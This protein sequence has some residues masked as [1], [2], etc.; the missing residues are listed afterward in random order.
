[1]NGKE[2]GFSLVMAVFLM[3]VVALLGAYMVTIGTTQQQV[4][5]L[6]ILGARTF[7]AAESGMEW[8]VAE[9]IGGSAC[10]GSPANFT[11]SGGAADGYAIVA[12]CDSPGTDMFR[13]AVTA[14]RGSVGSADYSRRSIRATVTTAP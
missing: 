9:V 10:F 8:G 2:R 7:A 3:V 13:I 1:M 4:S 6:S 14:T 5:T 12:T 11:L